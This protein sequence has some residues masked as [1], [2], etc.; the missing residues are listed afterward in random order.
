MLR[1]TEL[2]TDTAWEPLRHLSV[3]QK[4]SL[5][6]TIIVMKRFSL[7]KPDG[8]NDTPFGYHGKD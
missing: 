6:G 8:P 4:R 1:Y 2:K 5:S 3:T 7:M